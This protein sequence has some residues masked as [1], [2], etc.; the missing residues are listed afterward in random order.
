MQLIHKVV[1]ILADRGKRGLPVERLYRHLWREDLLIEAYAKIGKNDGATTPGIDSETVDGMSLD[2]IHRISQVLQSNDW[3]WSPARRVEIPKPKGGTRPLGLPKWSDKLIQQ[4]IRSLLEPYYE[5][6]FSRFS[7]GF[8]RGLGC[9]HAL[10]HIRHH[11]VGTKWFIEGDIVKCFDRIDHSTLL[12][13]LRE[14]VHDQRMIKLIRKMLEAGYLE[15]WT[16]HPTLTGTPQGGVLS[17]LL[18]N[19]YLD[20]LDQFVEHV[21]LPR[22]NRGDR[23]QENPDYGKLARQVK[24]RDRHKLTVDEAKAVYKQ[25]RTLPSQDMF[26][27]DYR[28]LRYVRYADDFLLGFIGPKS[29]AEEIRDLLKDFLA[30]TLKLDL[31]VEKTR[32]THAQEEGARFLGYEIRVTHGDTKQTV[33]TQGIRKRSVNGNVSLLVPKDVAVKRIRAFSKGGKPVHRT[34][35]THLSDYSIVS[36]YQSIFR[37]VVNF[38]LMAQNVSTRLNHLKRV[39][40]VSLLKTLAHKHKATVVQMIRKFRTKVATEYGHVNAIQVVVR[41][42]DRDDLVAT[43]GGLS[44]RWQSFNPAKNFVPTFLFGHT[45]LL[46]RIEATECSLC[47]ATGVPIEVHHLRRLRDVR[48]G[49]EP[50]QQLMI[51]MRRKT[52]AVCRRCHYD[53]HKGAYDGPRVRR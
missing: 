24:A 53:I 28:R 44:L 19:I 51:A 40:E 29:E 48:K 5:P 18:A 10:D 13:T 20:R 15:D 32:I 17:P 46:E 49:K 45:D 36:L 31:S 26:D 33:N 50:W 41:R 39:M 22:Y 1:G 30:S 23:R 37:G 6:Q 25:L 38:Y 34:E 27:P 7:F 35:L 3:H 42:E 21:L 16:Y 43:F 2:K 14:K 47:G 52:L 12:D 8:R 9:H 4:A 11:W